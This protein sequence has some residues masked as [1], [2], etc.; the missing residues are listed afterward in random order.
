MQHPP[1]PFWA[2]KA[3]AEYVRGQASWRRAQAARFPDD[4]RNLR[5]AAALDEL[6][7]YI[8]DLPETDR[9][10]SELAELDAF[11]DRDQFIGNEEVR[12][13]IGLWRFTENTMTM[14]PGDLIQDVVSL[15]RREHRNPKRFAT[16][17]AE[18]PAHER[19][20]KMAI[21]TPPNQTIK[22]LRDRPGLRSHAVRAKVDDEQVVTYCGT[23]LK[24]RTEAPT[25]EPIGGIEGACSLCEAALERE[26]KGEPARI[27]DPHVTTLD[28]IFTIAIAHDIVCQEAEDALFRLVGYRGPEKTA[29]IDT[30]DF[31][32]LEGAYRW[33]MIELCAT[34]ARAAIS[35]L[36]ILAPFKMSEDG[37][38][39]DLQ[40]DALDRF[41]RPIFEESGIGDRFEVRSGHAVFKREGE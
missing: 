19:K 24:L 1:P 21:A 37:S 32:D 18:T 20:N 9:H 6:A 14:R 36:E 15:I 3:V 38:I 4:E 10:L 13:W 34:V 40:G 2:A 41:L 33:A 23:W 25:L 11:D 8:E 31:E 16:R 30:G 5:S 22:W 7:L 39:A 17:R 26:A 28:D 27:E 35:R 12:R 29:P